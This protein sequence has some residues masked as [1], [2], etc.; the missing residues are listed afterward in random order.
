MRS[1]ARSGTTARG[2]TGAGGGYHSDAFTDAFPGHRSDA[3]AGSD[4]GTRGCGPD[5]HSASDPCYLAGAFV[6]GFRRCA[7]TAYG[8]HSGALSDA[9]SV[10][11]GH[12]A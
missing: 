10:T 6:A 8:T 12:G 11:L 7:S 4:P 9:M 3:D 1:A 5:A 2:Y